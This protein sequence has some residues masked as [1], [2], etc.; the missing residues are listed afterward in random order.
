MFMLMVILHGDPTGFAGACGH[1]GHRSR[2][3]NAPFLL[4]HFG[5]LGRLKHGQAGK[6]VDDFLQVGH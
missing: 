5:E 2:G 1:H 4:K 6:L 3:G